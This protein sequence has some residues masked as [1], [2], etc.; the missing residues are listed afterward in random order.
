[1]II[2]SISENID[3]EKRVAITPDIIKKYK[4]LGLEVHLIQNYANHLGINDKEYETEGAKIF[5]NEDE[6][7]SS[8]NAILQMSILN[9]NNLEKL[10]EKQI[11]IGVLNSYSNEKKNM[12]IASSLKTLK[13]RDLNS[14]LVRR[15]GRVYIINKKNPKFKARQK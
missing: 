12:K 3:T 14:K 13:K 8:S 1:M 4:S 11:L 9:Q 10:K 5:E 2:G 15:R 6:V 7:I